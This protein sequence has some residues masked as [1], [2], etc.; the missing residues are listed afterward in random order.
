MSGLFEFGERIDGYPVRIL[1]ERTVR[2]GA[3]IVF[4]FAMASF[5]N[6]WLTGNFQPTRVF[7]VAFAG[8]V[9]AVAFRVDPDNPHGASLQARAVAAQH[10]RLDP[11][12]AERCKAPEFAK[13]IGHE[14]KWKLHNKC[15]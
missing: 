6:T 5:M 13:A 15:S 2:A 12:E 3:G 1:N 4:F 7:V 8:L 14:E 9:S 10:G 11:A